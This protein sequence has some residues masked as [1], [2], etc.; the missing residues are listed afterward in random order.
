[1]SQDTAPRVAKQH[2]HDNLSP[3]PFKGLS[4]PHILAIGLIA[5]SVITNGIAASNTA[6][7]IMAVV[8]VGIVCCSDLLKS[9][10]LPAA[11]RLYRDG[12]K[13]VSAAAFALMVLAMGVSGLMALSG[14][15]GSR[16]EASADR[17]AIE[18]DR[19]RL[20]AT[21]AGARKT[22]DALEPTRSV[23]EL[24]ALV[25]NGAGVEPAAWSR[26]S[27][28]TDVTR[29]A[30]KTACQPFADASAELGRAQ[31]RQELEAV[32]A[33]S[34]TALAKLPAP[35]EAD[36]TVTAVQRVLAL[37]GWT[38]EPA[39]VQ[40][41]AAVLLVG[42]LELGSVLAWTVADALA[43]HGRS[44][45]AVG[46]PGKI[47]AS[48]A[49]SEAPARFG[50]GMGGPALRTTASEAANGVGE[51]LQP[52]GSPVA[53]HEPPAAQQQPMGGPRAASEPQPSL[54]ALLRVLEGIG[55][56]YD[57]SQT[58]LA[59]LLGC[60]RSS[61]QRLLTAAASQRLIGLQT[62]PGHRTVVKLL[63]PR[64]AAV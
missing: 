30:S 40:T 10:L 1:M 35:R 42:L 41:L 29:P 5:G 50:D 15:L 4:L 11:S 49:A 6:H 46:S 28:C 8:A 25:Q 13:G 63:R 54:A 27:H 34:D 47:D 3:L 22:L 59:R 26:T 31:R 38:V 61:A 19:A 7:G 51:A 45:T 20:T 39:T 52:V 23:G 17:S 2:A 62:T 53:A 58:E 16:V 64:L 57:G 56:T 21:N 37:G 9:S 60:K 18:G 44:L 48:N 43:G 24:Q 55:G 14:A 33:G 36:A 32:V 12:R